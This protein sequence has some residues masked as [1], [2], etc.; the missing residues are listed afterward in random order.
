MQ[1]NSRVILQAEGFG[2]CSLRLY[3]NNNHIKSE[4]LRFN[5]IQRQPLDELFIQHHIK[6]DFNGYSATGVII[7]PVDFNG[8]DV[9]FFDEVFNQLKNL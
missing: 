3:R 5:N 6:V 2:L 9:V 1:Q 7:P 4:V 8:G